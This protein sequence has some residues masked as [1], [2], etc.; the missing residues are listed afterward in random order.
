MHENELHYDIFL[1]FFN[2]L[3]KTKLVASHFIEIK[4]IRRIRQENVDQSEQTGL[5]QKEG[6]EKEGV[7]VS[8]YRCVNLGRSNGKGRITF[9]ALLK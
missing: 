5:F 1:S 7:S 3:N 2:H 6:L 9:M 8:E 4:S